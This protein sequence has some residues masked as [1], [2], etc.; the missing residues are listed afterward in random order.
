MY[1]WVEMNPNSSHF[2]LCQV[3]ASPDSLYQWVL[4]RFHFPLLIQY[5]SDF[6]STPGGQL[7][8]GDGFLSTQEG[9]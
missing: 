6:L 4:L 9:L 5:C 2:L 8:I 1:P 3:L 7:S